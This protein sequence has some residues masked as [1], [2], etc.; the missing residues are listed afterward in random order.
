MT[1]RTGYALELE[2]KSVVGCIVALNP[3]QKT[4]ALLPG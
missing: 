4:E 3:S 1:F 2:R